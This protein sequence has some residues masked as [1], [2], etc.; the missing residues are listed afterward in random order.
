MEKLR[1]CRN[2]YRK[3]GCF[4]EKKHSEKEKTSL[5]SPSPKL[6]KSMI[7]YHETGDLFADTCEIVESA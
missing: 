5:D 1:Q 3:G 4:D 7:A 6:N 2:N